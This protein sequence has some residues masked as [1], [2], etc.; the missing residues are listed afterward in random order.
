MLGSEDTPAVVTVR[1]IF[2]VIAYA[3]VSYKIEKV[4]KIAF[5]S[6]QQAEGSFNRWLK[7]FDSF[8]EGV[9]LLRGEE[10]IYSNSALKRQFNLE[11]TRG[12]ESIL[13]VLKATKIKKYVKSDQTQK[14]RNKKDRSGSRDKHDK[15]VE[16]SV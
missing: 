2:L 3:L 14:Q 5:L 7:T 6:G 12:K 16:I 1:T 15:V 13:K 4:S 10:I 9:A 8:P 11:A